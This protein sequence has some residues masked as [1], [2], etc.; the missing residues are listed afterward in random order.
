MDGTC[1]NKALGGPGKMLGVERGPNSRTFENR[2]SR[3]TL[4]LHGLLARPTWH[5]VGGGVNG[6]G[7]TPCLTALLA[8]LQP[9]WLVIT[10]TSPPSGAAVPAGQV[11]AKLPH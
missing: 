4:P 10:S 2:C 7:Q 5:C 8:V 1:I 9:A 6:R 3:L 11:L